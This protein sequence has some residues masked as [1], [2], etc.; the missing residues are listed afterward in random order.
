MS[1][2]GGPVP[3]PCISICRLEEASGLCAGCLRTL[4]EIAVWSVMSDDERHAVWARIAE[5]AAQRTAGT[6]DADR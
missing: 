5:R 3:S 6:S 4:D 2:A 1:H